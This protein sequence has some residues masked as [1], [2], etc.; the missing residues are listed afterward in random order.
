MKQ[1]VL[2]ILSPWL[3]FSDLKFLN[4]TPQHGELQTASSCLQEA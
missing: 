4:T 1:C 3:A 2:L